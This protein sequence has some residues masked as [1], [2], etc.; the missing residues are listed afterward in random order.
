MAVSEEFLNIDIWV[1]VITSTLLIPL[2]LS[3]K[4]VTRTEGG[5]MVL[6][7]A[8]YLYYQYTKIGGA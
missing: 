6:W 3:D 2:M 5:M 7:Y 1:M 4:K 8:G